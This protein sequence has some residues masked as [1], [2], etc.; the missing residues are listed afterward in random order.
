MAVHTELGKYGEELAVRYLI[1][2]GFQ[3]LHRN[4][5]YSRFEI[6]IIAEKNGLLHIVEVKLRSG[7]IGL[8]E[9]NV[10]AK[11]IKFL[12]KAISFF[13]FQ[14]PQYKDFRLN[15]LSIST[16]NEEPEFFFIEDVYI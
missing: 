8:P 15:I 4:W 9:D 12:L 10:T 14:N 13:L 5:R 3:I 7:K 1:S 16:Q 2:N 11:K 6:D